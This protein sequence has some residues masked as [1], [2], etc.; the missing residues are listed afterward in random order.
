MLAAVLYS[1]A[2]AA[3][4]AASPVHVEDRS[5]HKRWSNCW[6]YNPEGCPFPTQGKHGAVACVSPRLRF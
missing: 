6:G 4:I 3:P 2:L 5:L 1:L